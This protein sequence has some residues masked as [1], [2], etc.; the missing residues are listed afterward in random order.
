MLI[1]SVP[2]TAKLL[3]QASKENPQAAVIILNSRLI[4]VVKGFPNFDSLDPFTKAMTITVIDRDAVK[5]ALG[6]IHRAQNTIKHFGKLPKREFLGRLKSFLAKIDPAMGLLGEAR[7]V[8]RRIPDPTASFTVCLAGFPNAGKS[9]VLKAVTG[10]HA[11]IANYEFTTKTLNYGTA[12]LRHHPVQFVDTPGTL[13]RAKNNPIE[14]QAILALKHLAK[15]I[16]FVYDPFRDDAEQEALFSTTEQ[17]GVP[18]AIYA[19]K[20][21]LLVQT[22]KWAKLPTIPV[23]T[24]PQQILDWTEPQVIANAKSNPVNYDNE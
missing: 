20:Q 24:K 18:R 4:E 19:S 15:A 7:A 16:V 17:Y 6:R 11:Q 10:A 2:R 12:E 14:A 5:Q 13:N 8:L 3:E 23:F 22:P 9:T 1:P 21:D